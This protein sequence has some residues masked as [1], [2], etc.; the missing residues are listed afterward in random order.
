MKPILVYY[1]EVGHLEDQNQID[2]YVQSRNDL[3]SLKS[4]YHIVK[5]PTRFNPSRIDVLPTQF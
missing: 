1:V 2:D 4:N 3:D 5:V